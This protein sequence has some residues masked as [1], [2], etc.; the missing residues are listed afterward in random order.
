[1]TSKIQGIDF[2][3][4]LEMPMVIR[5]VAIAIISLCFLGGPVS[6]K[7]EECTDLMVAVGDS[8]ALNGASPVSQAK[9][10]VFK[11]LAVDTP[12]IFSA[13]FFI[14]L[15][16]TLYSY[17]ELPRDEFLRVVQARKAEIARSTWAELK[18]VLEYPAQYTRLN[19]PIPSHELVLAQ[20]VAKHYR[21]TAIELEKVLATVHEL[22]G[23]RA[24]AVIADLVPALADQALQFNYTWGKA[25][26]DWK[27]FDAAASVATFT[28]TFGVKAY[29]VHKY[30]SQTEIMLYEIK[31]QREKVIEKFEQG[32]VPLSSDP[33]AIADTLKPPPLLLEGPK[34]VL[35]VATAETSKL[36][37]FDTKE[38]LEFGGHLENAY[39]MLYG[40][41][42]NAANQL[43][44][45]AKWEPLTAPLISARGSEGAKAQINRATLYRLIQ[46]P[47]SQS[48]QQLVENMGL[49]EEYQIV[50]GV[51]DGG[52][53]N[54]V[55]EIEKY[56]ETTGSGAERIKSM[57]IDR[58]EQLQEFKTNV[59]HLREFVNK[60]K[61]LFD[62]TRQHIDR[63][64]RF[65][66][67]PSTPGGAPKILT[68][69]EASQL[70]DLLAGIE[71]LQD[72]VQD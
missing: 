32:V 48:R 65:L 14:A 30:R 51:L 54:H 41:V 12:T 39:R 25:R 11:Q 63:A 21:W 71:S 19:Y 13:P 50:L 55:S 20:K 36:E 33:S 28:I 69:Q 67:T 3:E 40:S 49:L 26:W 35:Q 6:L 34:E 66:A 1:M 53:E 10:Q 43:G 46:E 5:Y 72:E 60:L 4:L 68:P 15:G 23:L 59:V 2:A 37:R 45:K 44:L 31:S 52:F 70:S 27:H 17:N 57:L 24:H 61:N 8:L 47:L 18:K 64:S 7:A 62:R 42:L 16:R 58:K 56:I 38:I 22:E 29:L 9:A